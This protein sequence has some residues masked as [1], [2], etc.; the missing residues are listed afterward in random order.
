L[1]G[2]PEKRQRDADRTGRRSRSAKTAFAVNR[3][4]RARGKADVGDGVDDGADDL[5]GCQADIERRVDMHGELGLGAAER[6]EDADGDELALPRLEVGPR[7]GVAVGELDDVAAEVGGAATS[8]TW[9]PR[10][11]SRAGRRP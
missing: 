8:G 11:P 5:G 2:R 7:V 1:I 4:F 10:P 3:A 9:C 6:G